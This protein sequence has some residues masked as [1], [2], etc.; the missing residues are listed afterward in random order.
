MPDARADWLVALDDTFTAR[1]TCCTL[2]GRQA[3]SLWFD[4]WFEPGVITLAV[5]LCA[6]CRAERDHGH[7]RL[8]QL[9]KRRYGGCGT[10]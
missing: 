1:L 4:I 6:R 8:R 3:E 5:L 10:A 7:E 2:C 9:I